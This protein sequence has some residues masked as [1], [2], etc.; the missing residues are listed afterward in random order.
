[1]QRVLGSRK[2]APFVV[3]CT[4]MLAKRVSRERKDKWQEGRADG[5]KQRAYDNGSGV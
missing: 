2:S 3:A 4:E 5:P 1:M